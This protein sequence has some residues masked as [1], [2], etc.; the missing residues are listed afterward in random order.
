MKWIVFVITIIHGLI[1]LLGFVKG[2]DLKELKEVSTNVSRPLGLM[3]LF[4][5]IL[6]IIFGVM[7][8]DD[9]QYAWIVGLLAIIVSQALIFYFW[10]MAKLG[11]IPNIILMIVLVFLFSNCSFQRML[12]HETAALMSKLEHKND[13]IINESDIDN[14]PFA[15]QNW[16]RKSGVVG[17]R[18]IYAG[19]V[20]QQA[21]MKL[22]P[23][24]EHW[25]QAEALQY[26][27]I[28][29]HSFIWSVN[30][31]MNP[32]LSFV[33]R[34]KFEN[35]KGEMLIKLNSLIKVVDERGAKLDEGTLQRYLGEMVWFPSLA[36]SE[37]VVWEAINDSTAKATM[38]FMGTSGSGTFRFNANGEVTQF[39]ALRYNGNQT[40]AKRYEWVM[41]IHAYK[42]FEGIKVPT[43]MT[44]TWK[45][46]EGDW[47]WLK[48]EVTDIRYNENMD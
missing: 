17:R 37:H 9:I 30:V 7:Y 39:S 19:K 38:T 4:D 42:H 45:F 33:G 2:Y 22:K 44:A 13:S 31:E 25:M 3:W 24:Q 43:Q 21:Q 35:G 26:T 16:L 20:Y 47:T 28:E 34:D 11:T 46:D 27:S 15:V 40:D 5:A 10:K 1:H 6:F 41:D 29:N 36:L 8:F 48:M 18:F 32:M 12:K 14:L 23:D